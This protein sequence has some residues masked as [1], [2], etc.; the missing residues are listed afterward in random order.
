MKYP[1]DL[2]NMHRRWIRGIGFLKYKK[3]LILGVLNQKGFWHKMNDRSN[4]FP[5][6]NFL[7]ILNN[8]T[9]K[10]NFAAFILALAVFLGLLNFSCTQRVIDSDGDTD[11][12]DK[13][14]VTRIGE[15]STFEIATW[16]IENFPKA[17]D[18]TTETVATIIKNL[19]IDMIAVAEIG[20][21]A[22]FNKMLTNLPGWK[23]A[24][25][26]D[27]YFDGSYQ[28]TGVLYK[29]ELISVSAVKNIFEN[30]SYAFPRPPLV[31]FVQ[32]KDSKGAKF[33]FN[34]IVL[35]LK[36]SGG[37]DNEARRRAACEKLKE[38]IDLEIAAGA[39]PDF[40][41]AG[42]WNDVLTDSAEQNVFKVFLDNPD[43]YYFLTAP[44]TD[45][46]SY[47]STTYKSLID[48]IL[49]TSDALTDYDSG[50]TEVLYLD[51]QITGYSAKISDHRPVLA[52]F[53]GFY[54][55]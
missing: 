18:E 33:D 39:D 42:D 29:S 21:I 51:E 17:G 14:L 6:S 52:V 19:D 3:M 35:H 4:R 53:K 41:V 44:I 5:I 45:R 38:H 8:E 55:E 2:K 24:L 16:N 20:S 7:S 46:Y 54:L 22:A 15:S 49:I 47:I 27:V 25:S 43:Q 9:G 37:L 10:R 50:L 11:N 1:V 12:P 23:G 48:H 31:A 13:P 40:I 32:V 34:L 36:A 30:E 28:K 26:N